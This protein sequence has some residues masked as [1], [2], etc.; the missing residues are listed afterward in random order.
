MSSQTLV[1]FGDPLRSISHVCPFLLD[2]KEK[3]DFCLLGV[4]H[5]RAADLTCEVGLN[6]GHGDSMHTLV[7]GKCEIIHQNLI[8][9]GFLLMSV[10]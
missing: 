8:R 10:I 1:L 3:L 2:P 5:A 4:G 9:L 6:I 7:P